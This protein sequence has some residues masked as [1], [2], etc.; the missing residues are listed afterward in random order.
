MQSR[1][2]VSLAVKRRRILCP[3]QPKYPEEKRRRVMVVRWMR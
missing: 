2:L 3:F 1:E